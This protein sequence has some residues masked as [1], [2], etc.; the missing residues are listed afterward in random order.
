VDSGI[1]GSIVNVVIDSSDN[2]IANS[3]NDVAGT[4]VMMFSSTGEKLFET[5]VG[6]ATK[7]DGTAIVLAADGLVLTGHNPR[8]VPVSGTEGAKTYDA[9]LTKIDQ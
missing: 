8:N 9:Y 2:I 6:N 7:D 1:S 5:K 4:I 3:K